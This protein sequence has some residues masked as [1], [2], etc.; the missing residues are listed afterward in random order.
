MRDKQKSE[1][2][3]SVSCGTAMR[4]SA[5]QAL[6]ALARMQGLVMAAL[7]LAFLQS[8]TEA[9]PLGAA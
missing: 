2:A 6:G 4:E 9:H 3:L 8:T 7:A 5:L 1:I